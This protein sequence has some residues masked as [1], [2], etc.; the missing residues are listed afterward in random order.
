MVRRPG[1]ALGHV[2]VVGVGIA[3]IGDTDGHDHRVPCEACHA[4]G[5][6]GGCGRRTGDLG[7]VTVDIGGVRVVTDG[8]PARHHLRRE[9]LVITI[10]PAVEDGDG[11]TG[12][13]GHAPCSGRP[14]LGQVP[15]G[16]EFRVIRNV[17]GRLYQPVQ[18]GEFDMGVARQRPRKRQ[19]NDGFRRE[20]SA[21]S[22]SRR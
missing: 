10:D 7:P 4:R 5:I 8:I 19:R 2:A 15:G 22:C 20:P 21:P 12:G 17:L 18:F 1:Q 14:D 13:G 16:A 3:A 6:V 9:V 11:H